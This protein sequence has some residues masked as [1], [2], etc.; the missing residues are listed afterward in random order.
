MGKMLLHTRVDLGAHE[1]REEG[2]EE[3]DSAGEHL[4]M[5]LAWLGSIN[6]LGL[7][8]GAGGGRRGQAGDTRRPEMWESDLRCKD[9]Y[10]GHGKDSKVCTDSCST[11]G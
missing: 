8:S 4:G 11:D 5:S 10:V 3:N 9:G 2:E 7:G 1:E 6:K